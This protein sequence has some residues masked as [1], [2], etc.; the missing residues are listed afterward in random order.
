M[1]APRKF[2]SKDLMSRVN[3]WDEVF[4]FLTAF[5]AMRFL[6]IF[7]TIFTDSPAN[8]GPLG[9]FNVYLLH[10][11]SCFVFL[12]F[13][14][15]IIVARGRSMSRL[16]LFVCLFASAFVLY[17]SAI[18]IDEHYGVHL[19]DAP[20]LFLLIMSNVYVPFWLCVL[21][22]FSIPKFRDL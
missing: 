13:F 6:S 3:Y 18:R 15:K 19:Y 5:M 14:P 16:S 8:L 22:F 11:P 2:L 4:L 17:A 21:V 1:M 10:L 12:A 20:M 7:F 9:F